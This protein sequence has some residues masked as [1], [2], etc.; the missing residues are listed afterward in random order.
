[1]KLTNWKIETGI[2]LTF[3]FFTLLLFPA[4]TG[5]HGIRAYKEGDVMLGGLF[6]VHFGGSDDY[7]G[8]LYLKGLGHVEAMIF[9]IESVN[10]NPNLLPNVTIGYDIRNYCESMALAMKIAYEFVSN[11]NANSSAIGYSTQVRSK[12]ISALIGPTNSG[13]AVLVGSLLQVANI[14]AINPAATSLELSSQFYKD[15]FR[16]VPPDNWQA[17]VMADIIELFN[18]TYVAAVGLDDSYGRSGIWALERES[19]NRKSFCVAFSEFIPRLGYQQK[20]NQTVSKIKRKRNIG[21]VIVWLSGRYGRTFLTQETNENLKEKTFL[22]S[23]SMTSGSALFLNQRFKILSGSLG[24]QPRNYRYPAFDDHLKRITPAREI[25]IGAEWWKEFWRSQLNCSGERSIDSGV[26][27]CKTNLTSYQALTKLHSTFHTYTVNAVFAIAHAM[28]NIYNCSALHE[29]Q[30][31]DSCPSI[32]P[33]VMENHLLKYLRNVSFNGVTGKVQFDSFGDP[34]SASYDIVNFQRGPSKDNALRKVII[35]VWN[36]E[37]TPN[38]QINASNIRWSSYL[39]RVSG[40]VSFCASECLPGT[41]KAITTPCCWDCIECPQ[42]TISTELGSRRCIACNTQTKPNEG[43]TKCEKLPIINITLT[44]ATGISLAVVASIGFVLTLLV[45]ASYIKCYDTQIVKASS[46]EV[47]VLLLFDIA[48][49]F[50]LPVVELVEPSDFLCS[51]TNVWRYTGLTICITVL[52]SKLMRI[53]G[54]FELDKAGQLLKPCFK[55]AKKQAISIFVINSAT[56]F[57]K[58]LWMAFDPPDRQKIIRPDEYI[59]VVCKPFFTNTGRSLFIAVCAYML[60][61]ALLCT[62]YAFKARGIP[63]NFN[64]TKYTAFSMYIFLLSS[65]AYYPVLFN[66]ESWYVPLV[67][68]STTLITSFGLLSCMFGPKVYVL[69]FRPQQNTLESVRSQVSKY[70]FNASGKDVLPASIC[71]G[72]RNNAVMPV[73]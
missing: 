63:E 8:D 3:C 19:F 54:V 50:V 44:S 41:R 5:N 48:V 28:N 4:T 72:R 43:R 49:L 59:F 17:M 9:A 46:R 11:S 58:A 45:F 14:P 2:S 29:A 13:S 67:S 31:K 56:F 70:S 57:L 21:V 64:E 66:F 39:N 53:T 69:F 33:T 65:L 12:P 32:E 27:A 35:G 73:G 23:D 47:S 36:K 62:Y 6:S 52:F 10:K 25:E 24:I 60:T 55:T 30:E 7:C 40:P 68:C 37:I 71:A 61:V 38:L 26:A 18:W 20:I 51:A 22:L 42:G 16:T 34:F 1:M 15:F